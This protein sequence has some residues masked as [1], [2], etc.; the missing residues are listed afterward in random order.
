MFASQEPMKYLTSAGLSSSTV[1]TNPT[2]VEWLATPSN[3]A[4]V[5]SASA[6]GRPWAVLTSGK[7]LATAWRS[8]ADAVRRAPARL[9]IPAP[10]PRARRTVSASQVRQCRRSWDRQRAAT[11]SIVSPPSPLV[12]HHRLQ[13]L[14]IA[15]SPRWWG[16]AG[17]LSGPAAGAP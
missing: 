6:G 11:A 5:R 7:P 2:T 9:A 16:T 1:P 12:L 14:S 8:K 3:R 17:R 4:I 10:A 13:A 15:P